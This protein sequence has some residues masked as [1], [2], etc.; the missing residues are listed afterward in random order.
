MH[1]KI[2]ECVLCISPTYPSYLFHLD[3][4]YFRRLCFYL[5]KGTYQDFISFAENRNNIDADV[6]VIAADIKGTGNNLLFVRV[7]KCHQHNK[8]PRLSLIYHYHA[9]LFLRKEKKKKKE[10]EI[11]TQRLKSNRIWNTSVDSK[12]FWCHDQT[13][14][15]TIY[16]PSAFAGPYEGNR[17]SPLIRHKGLCPGL[18]IR[19]FC[20]Y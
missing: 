7:P 15:L 13:R 3:R 8:C 9:T 5:W 12:A 11:M 20:L 6:R 19:R 17:R 4:D 10:K 1:F 2:I 16:R 14:Q 18:G